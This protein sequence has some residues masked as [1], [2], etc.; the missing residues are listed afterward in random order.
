MKFTE[1]LWK[2][3]VYTT[4]AGL[5]VWVLHD[6]VYWYDTR[7][8]WTGCG[9]LPCLLPKA[10]DHRCAALGSL[11]CLACSLPPWLTGVP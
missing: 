1:S 8:F 6:E 7:H 5:A 9:A 11:A 2:A 10:E 4:F 3:T